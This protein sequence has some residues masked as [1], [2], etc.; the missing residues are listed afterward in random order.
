QRA[1]FLLEKGFIDKIVDRKVM[2]ETLAQILKLH[3]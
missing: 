1:E 3:L 2:K